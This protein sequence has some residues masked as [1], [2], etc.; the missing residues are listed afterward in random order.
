MVDQNFNQ[1]PTMTPVH[2]LYR[3]LLLPALTFILILSSTGLQAQATT[4]YTEAWRMYKKAEAD[5]TDNLLAKAQREYAEVID[6][7]LPLHQPEAELLRIKAELNQAK[8]AVKLGKVEGEKLILDFVRRYQPD[9]VANEALLEIANYYFNE[10]ELEKAVTYYKR[11]PAELLSA[12]Q[13]AEMN[14]RLGYASFVQK[15]FSEAKRYFQFSKST[16][17]EFYYPTNYY[18]GIIQF[19][20]GNYD[21]AVGQFRIA[22]KS[23]LYDDYIPYY[24]TQ[25][26]FA[27]R[28]YDELIAYAAPIVSGRQRIKNAKEMKQL[29]GQAYFEKGDYT[30]ARPYLEEYARNNRRMQEEELYQLGFTQYKLNDFQ[31]AGKSFKELAGQNSLV[32]Q[33]ASYYLGDIALRSGDGQA[34]RT[35][36]GTASRMNFDPALQEEALFNFAKLSYELGYPADAITALQGI[37]PSSRYYL[38]GQEL[39]G[40]VFNTTEDYQ[41]ALD[42]LERMPN[43]TPKLEEAYQRAA[44]SRGL[45]LLRSGD[46]TG[47]DALLA[48]SLQRPVN[49]NLRAQAL[50][51][52]AD[53]A[54]RREDYPTSINLTN[55]FLTLARGLQGLPPQSSL[56]TGNYLQ[57]YNY[58]KQD[59][60]AGAL[61]YFTAAVEGI[62]R[63]L[64]YI[65][66]ADVRER[67]LGDAVLRAGDA[68]FSRNQYDQAAR[69]YDDA[70]NRQTSGFV[71]ALFQKAM[72]EGL[73]GR[74][75][76]KVLA[77]EQL[78]QRYP[79]SPYADDALYQLALTYQELNRPQQALDPLRT[80]VRD[81]KVNSKLVNQSLL[82]L[83]LISYNLGNREAAINYYKQVFSNN[84]TAGESSRAKDALREIYVDDM[85]RADLFFDFFETLPGQEV[86]S[87]G[88]ENIS[89]EAAKG[90]Y[91]NGN[92]ERAISALTDYLRQYPQSPNALAATFYRGDSYVASRRYNEALPDYEAV[93]N[94]GPSN[95]YLPALKK[96]SLIAYNS[97]QDFQRAYRLFALLEQSADTE[98]VR[99]DAQVGALRA[100]YRLND[101]GA[102]E[103]Y[104]RKVANNPAAPSQ[105]KTTANFYLGKIAYDRNDYN[106][107]LPAFDQVIANSDDEQTAEA[108]YLRA[109]IFYLQRDLDRAQSLSLEA[110]R[111]SSGYPYWVAK[112][113]ILL[114]DILRDKKDLYNARAAL[115]ALLEN[116]Q[117][118]A[119]IVAEARQKLVRVQN[120]IDAGSRINSA[121][122]GTN[123]NYLELDNGG[124]Q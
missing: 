72:I 55:Q 68:Y 20:E 45:E 78:V 107:A 27:Q 114:S 16:Q 77:L 66:D 33:S 54:N 85:G 35:A 12:E 32:G 109:N 50:Y 117:G 1:L 76:D 10:N 70:I 99:L 71:Y 11:V 90:Q 103:Q 120:E 26:F 121:Q 63:N 34:A 44:F 123:P 118:D 112:T 23:K 56:Y 111:E 46:D 15:K 3:R 58:L 86:D 30:Q 40:E 62:E 14:F 124:G 48:K 17:G 18:L 6:M 83:G 97:L 21:G 82:Q 96:G 42:I 25:I 41:R 52:Q 69:F 43:R 79:K 122:P 13:R 57:G 65:T 53:L 24:L 49:P 38:Q 105:Q 39:L 74:N 92:Y 4:V 91:E 37:Q 19:F 5:Q 36:F 28:R 100:A 104:A 102:T 95:F 98:D 61:D 94:A 7:L 75:A 101:T 81:Y 47:A 113:V 84:P 80:I 8:I 2:Q 29:L 9:P 89:F 22:E 116:Y 67:V 106:T 87:D 115:E 88:R 110:N 60:Y 108:R 64:P 119:E 51:W 31:E 93:I 73:R 59:N